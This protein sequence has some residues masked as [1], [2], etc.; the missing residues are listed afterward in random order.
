MSTLQID[1]LLET[2]VKQNCSDLHLTT[3]RP[4]T[5][6]LNGSLRR[7]IDAPDGTAPT[8]R[9]WIRAQDTA[10]LPEKVSAVWE[11]GDGRLG[12]LRA[13]GL[14]VAAGLAANAAAA[15]EQ[16]DEAL[17]LANAAET[18]WLVGACPCGLWREWLGG[19]DRRPGGRADRPAPAHRGRSARRAP[20]LL[21]AA[22]AVL[23]ECDLSDR[24]LGGAHAVA[25]GH[26]REGQERSDGERGHC[27]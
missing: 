9:G 11:I 24:P 23:E 16:K 12:W 26:P 13:P 8:P 18:V 6:R 2:V 7:I 21:V 4:P 17:A 3:G 15:A 1:R 25:R 19:Y 27:C 20:E 5:V 10:V 14:R 22:I